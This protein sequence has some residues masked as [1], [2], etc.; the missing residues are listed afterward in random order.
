MKTVEVRTPTN[1]WQLKIK[2]LWL[3]QLPIAVVWKNQNHSCSP[4]YGTG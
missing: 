4:D 1:I 2:R 3:R